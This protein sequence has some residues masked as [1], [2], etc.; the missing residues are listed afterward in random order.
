M[1]CPRQQLPG[2]PPADLRVARRGYAL[3][4]VLLFVLFA[5]GAWA[6]LFHS[7]G[8]VLRVEE[9]RTLRQ[10]RAY[11][12]A[13]AM[14]QGLRLLQT[15]DPPA[16]P[17]ACKLALTQDGQTK[18]FRL[19]YAK[20]APIRWTVTASITDADDTNPDAPATFMTV[21]GVPAT[22]NAVPNSSTSVQLTWTDVA[23]DSGYEVERSPNGSNGWVQI[24]T[25]G[26]S[27][28]TYA[29][30]GADPAT[31]Y[32]YRVRA[33]N[34]VGTGTYSGTASATTPP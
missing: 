34:G 28:V 29:D 7:C 4:A 26:A 6:V 13:P 16:D 21:P 5:F 23:H 33:V 20:I 2:Q 1:S 24:A 15:G 32:Y 30:D 18:Y 25:T 3:P 17:Y 31:T 11:W 22:L 9:A 14:A 27:M 12:S 10:S 8:S 19:T